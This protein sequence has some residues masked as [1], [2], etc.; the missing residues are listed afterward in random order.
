MN[1]CSR[2]FFFTVFSFILPFFIVHAAERSLT[3]VNHE[4]EGTKQ[5]LPGTI[6][7]E[8]G[9]TIKLTLINNVPSGVHGFTI[10]DFAQKIDVKKG[11]PETLTFVANK[12]GI[13][14]ITCHLH[15]AHVGGQLIVLK[16]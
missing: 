15:K 14:P 7:V 3:I 8:E 9:D 10:E 13:F 2:Y 4:F 16:K 11:K 6:V 5:W 1:K 12:A